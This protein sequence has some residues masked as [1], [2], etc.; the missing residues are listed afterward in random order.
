MLNPFQ[1]PSID[2]SR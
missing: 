1:R 2:G